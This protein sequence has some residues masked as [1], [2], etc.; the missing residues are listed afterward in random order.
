M[1]KEELETLKAWVHWK[2]LESDLDEHDQAFV[3][4]VSDLISENGTMK[5]IIERQKIALK[6]IADPR[7]RDH[8]EPDAFTELGC[9]MNIADE[10]LK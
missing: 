7:L 3:K 2:K 4:A 8:K 5:A 9:V 6:K 10:A 1:N